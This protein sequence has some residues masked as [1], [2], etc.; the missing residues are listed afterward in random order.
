MFP[1]Y[2]SLDSEKAAY[3]CAPWFGNYQLEKLH[4][5][6]GPVRHSSKCLLHLWA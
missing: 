3:H 5:I 4:T 1:Y 2:L 6:L